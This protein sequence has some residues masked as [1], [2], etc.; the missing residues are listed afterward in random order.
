MMTQY[1]AAVISLENGQVPC[2][3]QHRTD[4]EGQ[5]G[6][7]QGKATEALRRVT[8]GKAGSRVRRAWGSRPEKLRASVGSGRFM[9]PPGSRQE[10]EASRSLLTAAA[11]VTFD[12]S[13]SPSSLC[14]QARDHFR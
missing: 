12:Y 14:P 4:E 5:N 8:V 6:G 7:M 9:C 3:S 2:Q 10:L 13:A 1:M 11:Q